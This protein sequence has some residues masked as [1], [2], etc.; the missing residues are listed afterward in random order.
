M[1]PIYD[2]MRSRNRLAIQTAQSMKEDDFF[3]GEK[4]SRQDDNRRCLA[5]SAIIDESVETEWTPAFLKL[6]T[7][8]LQEFP[9][10][11]HFG[12][13]VIPNQIDGQMHWTLMQLVGFADFEEACGSDNGNGGGGGGDNINDFSQ[14]DYLDCIQDSFACG[15]MMDCSHVTIQYVGVIA[16]ATGLLM[17]G[18]PSLDTNQVRDA[19]RARLQDRNL[20]LKEPFV[21]NICHSTLFRVTQNRPGMYSRLLEIAQLYQD[22]DL[23][24][25][26]LTKFQVGPASW[27]M[28]QAEVL[29]QT[30]PWRTWTVNKTTALEVYKKRIGLNEGIRHVNTLSASYGAQLA[31]ELQTTLRLQQQQQQKQQ[32]NHYGHSA[33]AFKS[34]RTINTRTDTTDTTTTSRDDMAFGVVTPAPTSSKDDNPYNQLDKISQT[35]SGATGIFL[36]A[37]LKKASSTNDKN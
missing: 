33:K 6:Q 9:N 17:I 5:I 10:D 15:G 24:S 31:K 19:L 13:A 27:R 26:K 1:D 29:H 34:M 8:L 7:T 37:E 4:A 22:V 35:V 30:P 3:F 32:Q 18:V 23:G 36:A 11:L 14:R 2:E 16:V 25:A 12:Q 20:P 28:L 21:N